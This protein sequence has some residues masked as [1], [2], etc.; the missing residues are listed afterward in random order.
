MF[1]LETSR[2]TKRIVVIAG[3]ALIAAGC[4]A[5]PTV[6]AQSP[7]PPPPPPAEPSKEIEPAS[8]EGSRDSITSAPETP[9]AVSVIRARVNHMSILEEDLRA[10]CFQQLHAIA[11]AP[12]AEDERTEA[13]REALNHTLQDVI[14]RE[15]LLSELDTVYAKKRPQYVSHLQG[16]ARKEFEKHMKDRRGALEK[17]G[18]PLKSDPQLKKYFAI[19]GTT[20]ESYRRHFERNFMMM[21]F[22]RALIFPNLR[23]AIGHR[24]IVEYYERHGSEFDTTDN[25]VWQDLF[26]DASRFRSRLEAKQQAEN[27]RGR[28]MRGDDFVKLVKD[29]DQGD[30]SWRG[31][32]GEGH[33]PGEIRPPEVETVL[34]KLKAGEVGPVVEVA[35]GF[36]VVKVTKREYNGRKPLNDELQSEIRKKLMNEMASREQ[37]RIL[38]ELRRK[39]SIEVIQVKQ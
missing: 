21:E 18:Y 37:R 36:H 39:A 25:L 14:D 33:R 11:M 6:R 30:S 15:L 5:A 32:E 35:N 23:A 4:A 20:L 8:Y 16:A 19:Q 38:V 34:F 27:V 10:G 26:V 7:P 22:L 9:D 1:T 29:F 13:I 17:H 2:R 3:L 28:A 31:G 12:I 24:E